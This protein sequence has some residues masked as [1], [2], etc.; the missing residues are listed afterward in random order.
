MHILFDH[1]DAE[2]LQKSFELDEQL[3]APIFII[4]DDFSFGPLTT[5]WSEEAIENRD[6]WWQQINKNES[7]PTSDFAN[8][9]DQIK[10][11][12][13]ES[14][15][16]EVW[17]WIAPNK[18]DTAGYYAVL[19]QLKNEF[20]NVH[21]LFLNNLPFINEKSA[22]FYPDFLSEL[23]SKEIVKA[24]RLVRP[25]SASELELDTDEW[26][27][28]AATG[29]MI[30]VYEGGK[31]LSSVKE[32]YFDPFI[33]NAVS[34][35]WQKVQKVL[36]SVQVKCKMKQSESFLLSR[37]DELIATGAIESKGDPL[38]RKEW[39]IKRAEG[40]HVEE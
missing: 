37:I 4:K 18:R 11:M 34:M 22:I 36:Q 6:A 14:N 15:E 21:V 3:N 26:N 27:K 9:M 2:A 30:R 5:E 32:N 7:A 24:K 17:I 8:Q 12:I 16:H 39:E 10:S 23:P 25:V 13:S 38:S 33:K 28:V 35:G 40:V 31:K 19:N 1:E 29:E 20:K